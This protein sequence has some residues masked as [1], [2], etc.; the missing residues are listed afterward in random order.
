MLLQSLLAVITS[1]LAFVEASNVVELK[2]GDFDSV[3]G[4]GKPALVEL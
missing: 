3:I 1:L 4:Q 2:S